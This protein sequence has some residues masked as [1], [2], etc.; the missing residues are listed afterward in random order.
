MQIIFINKSATHLWFHNFE[1]V[2]VRNQDMRMYSR[3]PIWVA[4]EWSLLRHQGY[5]LYHTRYQSHHYLLN[6]FP[7]LPLLLLP[8]LTLCASN[9][10]TVG[11][12]FWRHFLLIFKTVLS[13]QSSIR[14]LYFIRRSA[15]ILSSILE[16]PWAT[17]ATDSHWPGYIVWTQRC[18]GGNFLR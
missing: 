7:S 1:R 3:Q 14:R 4:L 18:F 13:I 9:A 16:S 17:F 2:C 5:C 12:G 6:K 8:R 10:T 15:G 11:T